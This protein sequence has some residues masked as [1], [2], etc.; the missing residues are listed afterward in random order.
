MDIVVSVIVAGVSMLFAAMAVTPLI[1]E[2]Q[3]VSRRR[4]VAVAVAPKAPAG[5]DDRPLAA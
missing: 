1:A 5:P 2:R 3:P 4:S